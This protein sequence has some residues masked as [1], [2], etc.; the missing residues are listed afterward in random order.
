MEI[1]IPI[2][3]LKDSKTNKDILDNNGNKIP[4]ISNRRSEAIFPTF[5]IWNQDYHVCTK[6]SNYQK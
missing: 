6:I 5:Y 1:S 2:P 3:R 4:N